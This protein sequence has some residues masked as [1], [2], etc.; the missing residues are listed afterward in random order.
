MARRIGYG[1]TGTLDCAS[2]GGP[3]CFHVARRPV[4]RLLGLIGQR[5]LGEGLLMAFPRC[6][7]IHTLLMR[8]PID[9]LWL[10]RPDADGWMDVLGSVDSLG[11]GRVAAGPRGTWCVAEARAGSVAGLVPTRVRVDCLRGGAR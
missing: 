6:R 10:G 1:E 4:D 11:P 8:V 5:E 7:S 2:G 3:M 9:V